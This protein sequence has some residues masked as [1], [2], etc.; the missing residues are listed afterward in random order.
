[1]IIHLASY[2]NAAGFVVPWLFIRD[3]RNRI[4]AASGDFSL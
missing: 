2:R 1:M 4:K 3:G